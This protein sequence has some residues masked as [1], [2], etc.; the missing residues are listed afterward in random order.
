MNSCIWVFDRTGYFLESV[1]IDRKIYFSQ[2]HYR[3]DQTIRQIIENSQENIFFNYIQTCLKNNHQV[4]L[5]HIFQIGEQKV[6]FNASLYP[7]SQEKVILIPHEI[8][9]TKSS[10]S[11]LIK[12]QSIVEE[13]AEQLQTILEA[14]P[15]LVS[16]ISSD[17]HYL[18]A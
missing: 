7:F 11:Q 1:T 10:K 17:L 8:Q 5:E 13:T 3:T 18:G 6:K 14:I 16:W 4:E 9:V 15:G 2:E 12:S